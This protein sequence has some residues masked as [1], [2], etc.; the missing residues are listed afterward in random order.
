MTNRVTADATEVAQLAYDEKVDEQ[1]V[2]IIGNHC[3][4]QKVELPFYHVVI[5]VWEKQDVFAFRAPQQ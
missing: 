3:H 4:G 2:S 1:E 5:Q